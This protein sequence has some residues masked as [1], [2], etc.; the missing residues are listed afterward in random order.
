MIEFL[1]LFAM[2]WTLAV[3][4]YIVVTKDLDE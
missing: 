2:M 3:V 1:F 4:Y